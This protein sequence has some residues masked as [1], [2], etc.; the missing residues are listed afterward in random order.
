[1]H[2]KRKNL[3]KNL[4]VLLVM[5]I[6]FVVIAQNKVDVSNSKTDRQTQEWM[7]KISSNSEM[8]SS[9]MGMM[10]NETRGNKE[11]M[12]KLVSALL[13]DQDVRKIMLAMQPVEPVNRNISV[14]P[15]GMSNDSI[16]VMKMD[17]TLP[18]LK[19]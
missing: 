6:P 8:R 1:M 10:I 12:T 14:E 3:M 15:K 4:I 17:Y 11:E 16:K 13:N 19:K 9:M 18:V 7:K 2:I 5:L